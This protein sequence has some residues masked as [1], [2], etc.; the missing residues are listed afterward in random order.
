MVKRKRLLA[1]DKR[2]YSS[3]KKIKQYAAG[4]AG[5]MLGFIVDNVPG[6]IAGFNTAYGLAGKDSIFDKKKVMGKFEKPKL[7][8]ESALSTRLVMCAKKGKIK[9]NL[10][11]KVKVSKSL[12]K[13]IGKV[14]EQ[15]KIHGTWTQL[16]YG[17]IIRPVAGTQF[18]GVPTQALKDFSEYWNFTPEDFLHIASVLFNGKADDQYIR[19]IDNSANLG[20]Q[21]TGEA[22]PFFKGAKGC[23][24]KFHVQNSYVD[25]LLKNNTQNSVKVLAYTFAIKSQTFQST[26]LLKP[27]G[28]YQTTQL[29]GMPAPDNVWVNSLATQT[30]FNVTGAT[31]D[32]VGM[33][34]ENDPKMKQLYKHEVCEMNIEPGQS[35]S[36]RVQ[37]PSDQE[38]DYSKFYHQGAFQSL[39]KF[40]RGTMF[41]V[42]NEL[43]QGKGDVD[44]SKV[45]RYKYIETQTSALL[46]E[47]KMFCKISVPESTGLKVENVGTAVN[48]LELNYRQNTFGHRV[49][50]GAAPALVTRVDEENPVVLMT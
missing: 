40:S 33:R 26:S 14:L 12:R 9:G 34:P 46:V 42:Y 21:N 32:A 48:S 22:N 43:S 2:D 15:K 47:K 31:V 5:G 19:G 50:L 17:Y 1:S 11:K 35:I 23:N 4:A 7:K 29:Q 13:K 10:K 45:G 6:A 36:F 3:M 20:I 18:V 41:I 44:F 49:Y 25:Y 37:G 24:A 16:S 8:N 27:D 38:L 30:G 28:T 39:Q